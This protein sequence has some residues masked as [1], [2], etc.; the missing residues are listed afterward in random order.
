MLDR[1]A[2][3]YSQRARQERGKAQTSDDP[4]VRN[5]HLDLANRYEAKLRSEPNPL[6]LRLV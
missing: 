3:Y 1:D 4:A 6:T 2:I 5:V